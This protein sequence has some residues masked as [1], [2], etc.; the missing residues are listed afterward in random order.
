MLFKT[1]IFYEREGGRGR[2]IS[3]HLLRILLGIH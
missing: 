2:A 3:K 1:H